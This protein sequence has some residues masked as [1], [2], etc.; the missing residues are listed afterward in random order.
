[1]V[2]SVGHITAFTQQ[3]E[4]LTATM[5]MEHVTVP[6][7]KDTA[8]SIYSDSR[9]HIGLIGRLQKGL[10]LIQN[11]KELI[12]EGS[13]FGAPVA[14]Y[15]EKTYFS[16]SSDLQ[17]FRKKEHTI[18]IKQFALDVQPEKW[19][20]KARVENRLQRK[21]SNQI[22][23]LYQEHQNLRHTF[24][25]LKLKN[26]SK[27][28]GVH[29]NFV[30][31]RTI[32]NVNVTYHIKP[33]IIH[34]KADFESLEKCGLQKIF[35]MN[36]QSSQYFSR[37]QDSSGNVSHRE[38]IGAWERVTADWACVSHNI[39]GIGFRLWQVKDAVLYIGREFLNGVLDWIGFDYEVDPK[40]TCFEYD[41]E[42]LGGEKTQ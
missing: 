8:L 23:D 27:S 29:T 9:P 20:R 34:V 21:L 11:C 1:M 12:G 10:I 40:K 2:F 25:T 39:G 38:S 28:I 31:S 36:E 42:V 26:L 35:L 41:I 37:Y 17:V 32:G 18:C 30:R 33:P 7:W 24:E 16:G 13:G 3:G 5:E 14:F 4:Y 6:F 15:Q 22:A 19:F